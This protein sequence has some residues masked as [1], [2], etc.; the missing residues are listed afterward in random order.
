MERHMK[1]TLAAGFVKTLLFI[2]AMLTLPGLAAAAVY[3]CPDGSYQDKPCDK[4][5]GKAVNTDRGAVVR[6]SPDAAS[7]SG[8]NCEQ[9]LGRRDEIAEQQRIGGGK[10]KMEKLERSRKDV[11]KQ[12]AAKKCGK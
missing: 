3:R 10:T 5:G 8:M 12:I 6:A 4:G 9:L 7:P 1:P 11:A 2:T